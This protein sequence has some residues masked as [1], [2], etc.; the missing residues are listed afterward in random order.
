MVT[1]ALKNP[2]IPNIQP[3]IQYDHNYSKNY[4]DFQLSCDLLI[5]DSGD[6]FNGNVGN[7]KSGITRVKGGEY[8]AWCK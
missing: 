2:N 1:D 6:C 5:I 4:Y 7:F 8:N 3:V